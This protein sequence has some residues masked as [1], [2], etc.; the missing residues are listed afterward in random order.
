MPTKARRN[1]RKSEFSRDKSW[2]ADSLS[3]DLDE[4]LL[5]QRPVPPDQP[6]LRMLAKGRDQCPAVFIQRRLI[7]QN[8]IDLCLHGI[9]VQLSPFRTAAADQKSAPS[10]CASG[11]LGLA[12]WTAPR[13]APAPIGSWVVLPGFA[14]SVDFP[15]APRCVFSASPAASAGVMGASRQGSPGSGA[16]QRKR[17]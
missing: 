9:K 11:K 16:F 12:D 2:S 5:P 14:T 10:T 17:L 6:R 8:Q 4:F 13:R 7:G 15:G 1:R 3:S